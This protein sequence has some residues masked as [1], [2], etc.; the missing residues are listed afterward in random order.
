MFYTKKG[1]PQ[2][3]LQG[4]YR[5]KGGLKGHKMVQK[6]SKV[7]KRPSKR[8]KSPQKSLILNVQGVGGLTLNDYDKNGRFQRTYKGIIVII[9]CFE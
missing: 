8:F 5:S 6:S 7:L 4:K 3:Y 1:R 2:Y 9:E